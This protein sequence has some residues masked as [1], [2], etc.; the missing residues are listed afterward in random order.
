M[1]NK[2]IVKATCRVWCVVAVAVLS[3]AACSREDAGQAPGNTG[4]VSG[5]EQ[6][7][8][9]GSA[10]PGAVA[11]TGAVT[12]R[13]TSEPPWFRGGSDCAMATTQSSS[14]G[15]PQAYDAKGKIIGK[16]PDQKIT[17]GLS[18]AVCGDSFFRQQVINPRSGEKCP[19][20]LHFSRAPSRAVC[21]KAWKEAQRTK[22]PCDPL[23][24]SDCD[25][26]PNDA[27]D[28]PLDYSKN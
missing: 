28:Y 8:A 18:Y 27:D 23:V 12:L 6:A 15:T 16:L 4:R 17:C 9:G 14:W 20:S 5:Q 3:F 21:C 19:E 22:I 24:D 10:N 7:G 25:G 1:R 11:P 26:T 2:M 13:A